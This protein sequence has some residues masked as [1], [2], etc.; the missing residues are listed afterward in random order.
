MKKLMSIIVS[1]L[2]ALSLS[3]LCFAQA[4]TPKAAEPEKKAKWG[5]RALEV[6]G[7]KWAGEI[8]SV[9]EAAKTVVAK[10]KK[11]ETTFD[12]SVAKFAKHA[13]FEDLKAGYKIALKYEKK[14]GKNMAT[15]V[16]RQKHKHHKHGKAEKK[17]KESAQVPA[18]AK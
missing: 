13:T 4:P 18:P 16:A 7:I 17:A 9:D 2:F 1:M 15:G 12:L 11:G 8:V 14:D 5:L 6:K 10:N 3:G